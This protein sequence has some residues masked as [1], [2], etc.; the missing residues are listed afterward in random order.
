MI[1]KVVVV[2]VAVQ[3]GLA[4][5]QEDTQ[6]T[7]GCL[8]QREATRDRPLHL[9]DD[10]AQVGAHAEYLRNALVMVKELASN[11]TKWDTNLSKVERDALGLIKDFIDDLKKSAIL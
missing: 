10:E 6:L 9:N 2:I 8:L 1:H 11:V 3:L 7:T 4:T 5:G